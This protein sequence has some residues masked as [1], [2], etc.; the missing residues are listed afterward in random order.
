MI[1]EFESTMCESANQEL[2]VKENAL[3]KI[4]GRWGV[5]LSLKRLKEN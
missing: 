3:V 5:A 1:N 2:I 4:G